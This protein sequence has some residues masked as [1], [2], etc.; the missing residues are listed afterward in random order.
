MGSNHDDHSHDSS[1][2]PPSA[3]S[4]RNSLKDR[5]KFAR[6][7]EEAG[8]A[9][10]EDGEVDL[11]PIN[12]GPMAGRS[13]SVSVPGEKEDQ[14]PPMSRVASSPGPT[15]QPGPVIN[16]NLAPG[17][18][19]GTAIGPDGDLAAPVDWDLWQSVVYEGPAAVARTSAEELN[20]AIASGIPQPIRGVVWQVLAQSKNEG[21]ESVYRELVNR[22]TAKEKVI[23]NLTQLPT[24]DGSGEVQKKESVTS[25][26]S[27]A[28]SDYST[29][30]TT[31]SGATANGANGMGSPTQNGLHDADTSAKALEARKKKQKEDA[32]DIQKLERQIKRD[33]GARTSYSKYVMAAG[34]QDGLFNLCKAY[35]LFDTEVGYPQGVNFIAMP[36]LFNVGLFR[37][38]K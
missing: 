28:H 7:R 22:G 10:D 30:A 17:T 38:L 3:R 32:A 21:L 35:A 36:L 37:T 6:M 8:I 2:G 15:S 24:N 34:L 20:A 19:V 25:S 16:P 18:A 27:S 31:N 23:S 14:A 33:L 9:I 13:L 26:A 29:P 11:V 12:T 4:S 5:F 1:N